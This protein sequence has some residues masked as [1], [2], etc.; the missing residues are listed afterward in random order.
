MR[1]DF[2]YHT[3]TFRCGHAA[4]CEDE[5]YVLSALKAGFRTLGFSDHAPY[6]DRDKPTDRMDY[7]R[8]EE[9]KAAFLDALP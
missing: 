3:H 9:I 4:T 6:P 1:Q 8:L 5:E 2:N 7:D